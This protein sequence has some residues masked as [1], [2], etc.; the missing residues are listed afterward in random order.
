MARENA[1]QRA[2]A[3]RDA[4]LNLG[5][6]DESAALRATLEQ[7]YLEAQRHYHTLQHLDECLACLAQT[8]TLAEHPAE[9]AL[10]LWFHDAIYDVKAHDNEL[11]SAEWAHAACSEAGINWASAERIHGLV[12]AT[13]H[14][15]KPIGKDAEL[16]VDIDLAILAA[17]QARYQQYQQQIRQEYAWVPEAQFRSAR[18]KILEEFLARPQLFNT[19]YFFQRH[20]AQARQN[21]QRELIALG[22]PGAEFII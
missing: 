20:E 12:L 2:K 10:A 4:W 14:H 21:V 8:H 5:A 11:R 13:Q 7:S 19:A 9:V 3:W 1:S 22:L 16:L 6:K 15:A 17:P 18:S